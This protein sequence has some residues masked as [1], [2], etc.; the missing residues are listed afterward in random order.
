MFGSIAKGTDGPGSDVDLLV[1]GDVDTFDLHAAL[2]GIEEE[3]RRHVHL[4]VY[5]AD[6]WRRRSSDPVLREIADGPKLEVLGTTHRAG[7]EI[8]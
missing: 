6:E 1:A 2:V 3:L 8:P 4:S 7:A 5:G